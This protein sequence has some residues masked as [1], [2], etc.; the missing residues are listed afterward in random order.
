MRSKFLE[1]LY[2]K[3]SDLFVKGI[4]FDDLEK[5]RYERPTK[6]YANKTH[7]PI[8]LIQSKGNGQR[9]TFHSVVNAYADFGV[10][11]DQWG[12][13]YVYTEDKSIAYPRKFKITSDRI[14][15]DTWR[16]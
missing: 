1:S 16:K 6:E 14:L 2:Y 15:I 13:V 5:G 12:Q 8:A 4:L 3:T 9:A 11:S 7:V 10:I